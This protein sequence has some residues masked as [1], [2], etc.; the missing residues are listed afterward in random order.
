MNRLKGSRCYLC[1]PIDHASDLGQGWRQ[2]LTLFLQSL[3]IVVLDPTNKPKCLLGH[4]I[5]EGKEFHKLRAKLKEEKR[6]DELSR[7]VRS[8]RT[9]DLRLCDICDFCIVYWNKDIKS[10]GTLEELFWCNRM[11]K[12]IL[13]MC[14][15]GKQNVNDWLFGTINHELMFSSWQEVKDYLLFVSCSNSNMVNT[16][17]RWLLFDI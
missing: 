4:S 13:L 16:F 14:E 17:N 3:E 7:L 1:G 12:P 15:Q 8:I 11:K 2:E 5:T 10:C 6:Y 9:F